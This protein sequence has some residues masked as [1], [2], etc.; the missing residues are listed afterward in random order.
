LVYALAFINMYRE[1]HPW[2]ETSRWMYANVQPGALIATELWDDPLPSSM[3]IDG[4]AYSRHLYD[5][6]E[7]TWLR[8]AGSADDAQK[9]LENLERVA[10][11]DYLVLSSNRVYGVVSRLEHLYPLSSQYYRQLFSGD[12]GFEVV[13]VAHRSPQ[14]GA[15][16]F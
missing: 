12:L 13:S 1:E 9:L 7:L 10:A 15:F 4:E 14:L 16:S 3:V 11:S 8:E 5:Y 6:T 2:N